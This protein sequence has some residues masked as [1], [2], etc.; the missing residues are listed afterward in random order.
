VH[1]RAAAR[2]AFKA[3]KLG[4]GTAFALGALLSACVSAPAPAPVTAAGTLSAFS[5]RRLDDLTT[6]LPP[7][8]NGWD[9]TQWFAAALEL[10]PQLAEQRAAVLAAAA[11]E[12]TAAEHPNPNI[13][14]FAEYLVSAAQSGAWLYGLSLDFLL[15]QPGERARAREHAALETALADSGLAEAIWQVRSALR[16]A[17]LDAVAAQDESALLDSLTAARQ[18]LLDSDRKRL[19][20]G[21]IARAQLLTDEL[22]LTRAT[23]RRQQ[24]HTRFRD[25]TARLAGAV[26]VPA[27][28]LDG[29]P[30]RWSDWAAID[31]LSIEA[32]QQWR[33][34]ALVGRPQI[35]HA[36]REYD[37]AELGVRSEVAKRWPQLQLTPAYAWGGGG[38]RE[39][40]LN[41]IARDSAVGV[42]F[43][44]PVFNQHQGA[45]GEAVARRAAAGEHLK[46]VQADIFEQIDRAELAWPAARQ[47]WE[48]M[49][50]Q[51][52]L[53]ERQRQSDEHALAAGAGERGSV[54]TSSIAA[55]EAHLAVL[56]AAYGA[57]QAFGALEDAYRRPLI[58]AASHGPAAVTVP[59]S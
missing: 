8:A 34:D 33:S 5:A 44:L 48:D 55:T 1:Q 25:A 16:E 31:R 50:H 35:V 6:Q 51:A 26:G 45:I 4:A 43:E 22:E 58:A 52:E 23:A 24:A 2:G 7:P 3:W 36:L 12:R 32:P 20:L 59:R 46:A 18:Q 57:Q 30:L 11:G 56:E 21:D 53:S 40:A 15:R 13:D 17:L 9:R 38:V 27:S 54:L 29:V 42:S 39:D 37:L 47:G 41:D 28:A 49:Q 14:L 10:N 19:A